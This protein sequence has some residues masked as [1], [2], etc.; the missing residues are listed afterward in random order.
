MS[1]VDDEIALLA[2][3]IRRYSNRDARIDEALTQLLK[4][5]QSEVDAL[6]FEAKEILDEVRKFH[7]WD[8]WANRNSR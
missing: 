6:A 7:A 5:Y 3:D 1:T 8:S 2:D 4:L